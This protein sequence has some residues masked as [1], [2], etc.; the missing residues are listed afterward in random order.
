MCGL[1]TEKRDD[2]VWNPTLQKLQGSN[3]RLHSTEMIQKKTFTSRMSGLFN[4]ET[5]TKMM[6]PPKME[7][8]EKD[9]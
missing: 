5:K 8:T 9:R 3:F 1:G 6:Q 4:K 2:A 7:G